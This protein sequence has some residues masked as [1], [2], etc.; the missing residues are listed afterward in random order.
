LIIGI[1]VLMTTPL[2]IIDDVVNCV[3]V[4]DDVDWLLLLLWPYWWWCDDQLLMVIVNCV[5]CY[6]QLIVTVLLS[7]LMTGHL[8]MTKGIGNWYWRYCYYYYWKLWWCYWRP[9]V[10]TVVLTQHWYCVISDWANCEYVNWWPD[11]DVIG[12]CCCCWQLTR[13]VIGIVNYWRR[14]LMT[15]WLLTQCYYWP[16]CDDW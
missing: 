14:T 1:V 11:L 4:V 13:I 2:V 8:L 6:W 15:R 12:D 3:I 9:I 5:N 10:M 16:W 7:L